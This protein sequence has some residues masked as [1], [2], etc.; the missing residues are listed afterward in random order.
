[1]KK[2]NKKIIAVLGAMVA[3]GGFA[4][5][6]VSNEVVSLNDLPACSVGSAK[7]YVKSMNT[8][9]PTC[10]AAPKKFEVKIYQISLVDDSGN[11]V[12]LYNKQAPDYADLIGSNFNP[13]RDLKDIPSGRYTK[14]KMIVDTKYRVTI[15]E[16]VPNLDGTTSRVITSE[17]GRQARNSGSF[18]VKNTGMTM[19]GTPDLKYAIPR[20]DSSVAEAL[21]IKHNAYVFSG[22]AMTISDFPYYSNNN[23]ARDAAPFNYSQWGM[24]STWDSASSSSIQ[25]IKH[26]L[27][28]DSAGAAVDLW[29][30]PLDNSSNWYEPY[31][32]VSKA[33]I[34]LTLKQPLQYDADAG[35]VMTW[36]WDVAKMF[37]LGFV[38]LEQT[39][40]LRY[41]TYIA[42]SD[43]NFFSL[44]PYEFSLDISK[45][46]KQDSNLQEI[47]QI[48]K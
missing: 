42:K 35:Y 17:S 3:F 45:V 27:N 34:E 14:I 38:T 41:N 15:D 25:T 36:S 29:T 11:E 9:W 37:V 5:V 4:S 44:G 26:S 40:S 39:G 28:I 46:T 30:H 24:T 8:N 23:S 6:N 20:D 47:E 19:G 21:E 48:V 33:T 16:N 12:S 10:Y 7:V 18:K 1:M 22:G 32:E 2:T 13:I 43:I 31:N